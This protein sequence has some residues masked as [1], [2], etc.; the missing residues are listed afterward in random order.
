MSKD[1]GDANGE[2]QD[3]VTLEDEGAEWE[4]DDGPVGEPYDLADAED[5]DAGDVDDVYG[6]GTPFDTAAS[7]VTNWAAGAGV[8]RDPFIRDFTSGLRTRSD[9]TFWAGVDLDEEFPEPVAAKGMNQ[10]AKWLIR[11]RN[12]AVFAPVGLTWWAISVVTPG[13]AA[14]V[15]ER[16]ALEQEA[17][18][19]QYWTEVEI[20]SSFFSPKFFQIQEIAQK[21]A[22]IILAIILLTLAAQVMYWRIDK[23]MEAAMQRRAQTIL[24]VRR[25]LHSAREATPESLA[26][27]LAESMT[28]LV[29]SSRMI[30]DAARRLEQASVGVSQL[31][32]TFQSLNDQLGRFDTRLGDTII[33]SVD[34]LNASVG[35]LSSLM[36]GN[37][38]TLLTES[39]AGIDEVREQLHRTAASVEFGTQQLLK[40]LSQ[41]A[42]QSRTPRP[43]GPSVTVGRS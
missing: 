34:R 39:V 32:P 17:N 4:E 38:R 1:K 28:E 31:E 25:A 5:G 8:D 6:S 29:E 11:L 2:L 40:D 43:N 30:I 36:D 3:D 18:F 35:S 41:I 27:S 19:F 10:L 15:A 23:V 37:L 13:F 16:E 26:T 20:A 42:P 7:I 12:V 21:G 22:W 33:G 9:L 24:A 14:Y